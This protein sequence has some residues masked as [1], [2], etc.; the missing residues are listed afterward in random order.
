MPSPQTTK[1]L[2]I[3]AVAFAKGCRLRVT[4]T[5][6]PTALA[7]LLLTADY[8]AA[9]DR[10]ASQDFPEFT[11]QS[12]RGYLQAVIDALLDTA[13]SSP[14]LHL[15]LARVQSQMGLREAA[16]KTASAGLLLAPVKPELMGFLADLFVK[17]DRLDLARPLLEEACRINPDL[18]RPRIA[19]GMLL[20][21]LGEFELSREHY[22]IAARS[23]PDNYLPRL[24]LGQSY[25][26]EQAYEKALDH[27]QAAYRLAPEESPVVYAL[28]QTQQRLGQD[29][30]AALSLKTFEKLN[31]QADSRADRLNADRNNE[32]EMR[33]LA[34]SLH[35]KVALHLLQGQDEPAAVRHLKQTV[36]LA[37][38]LSQ[39]HRL[40]VDYYRKRRQFGLATAS[41]KRLVELEP[42]QLGYRVD[43]GTL[44]LQ[45]NT[46][47]SGV[48]ILQEVL[49]RRPDQVQAL[50][51]LSRY[52]LQSRTELETALELIRKL[53]AVMPEARNY[54][55]LAWA[56]FV[57]GK[58]PEATE[59]AAEALRLAP[60]NQRY[61][62][63]LNQL[64]NLNP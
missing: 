18:A 39:P 14:G 53:V 10:V 22:R 41:L 61:R 27:L 38:D 11:P 19:L 32:E 20:T 52:Y 35:L 2:S 54:D 47:E 62:Q 58:L 25:T 1:A 28:W 50:H 31:R 17:E 46:P 13:P 29:Q 26:K 59:A 5:W 33:A 51:N 15:I 42:E 4:R 37:P 48:Q 7:L 16:K 21:R 6:R 24:L 64:E 55:L 8:G 43:L 12:S 49:K 63:R 45:S 60:N 34:A 56:S 44:L 9:D 30:A 36:R 57:N 23:E 3:G 40:L